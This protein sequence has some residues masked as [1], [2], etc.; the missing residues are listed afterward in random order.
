MS[1]IINS[2]TTSPGGLIS[3]GDSANSLLIQTGDTTAITINSSQQVALT[4]PLGTASGGTGLSTVGTNGQVLSSNG[5]T[6]SWT[7]PSAGFS[8]STINAPSSS[9]LTLTN[10]ST[11]YQVVQITT[12]ANNVV[13]LPNATTLSSEG[14]PV[15]VIQNQSPTGSDLLIKNSA[16]SVIGQVS[17]GAIGLVYLADNSTSA[18]QWE[19]STTTPQ[20]FLQINADTLTTNA[21][22]GTNLNLVGLSTTS[23]VRVSSQNIGSG[24]GSAYVRY[25]LQAGTISGST[26]TFGTVQSFDTP[27][28]TNTQVYVSGQ[29]LQVVRLSN[30]AFAIKYGWYTQIFDGGGTLYGGFNQFRTCTVSGT[31]ISIGSG[32]AG[33]LPF[34]S[35]DASAI[36]RES[37]S[38]NGTLTRLSDTSF[39]VVYNDAVTTSYNNP[40]NF[41]GSL[42]V[43]IVTVS[44][45]TQTVGTKATLGT[46]TYSQVISLAS[47]SSTQLFVCYAQASSAGGSSGRTKLVMVS[48]S[49]TTATWNSPTTVESIDSGLIFNTLNIVNG[50]V[51]PSSTQIVYASGYKT[52]IASLSGTTLTYV[53]SPFNGVLYPLFIASSTLIWTGGR[54]LEYSATGFVT[55]QYGYINSS[56]VSVEANT[57][58]GAQPT[59]LILASNGTGGSVMTGNTL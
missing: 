7:T 34:V 58:L 54:Y 35:D 27:T 42:S 10:T 4:N 43:Q 13:V 36:R 39:A 30:T 25:Y 53:S 8:G 9:V 49:G 26:I 51:S 46:S 20:S 44:G 38:N 14:F 40:Y 59:T 37:F 41:S 29:Q 48:V 47:V 17:I 11:Q 52:N 6:L 45:T 12:S 23:F 18:G 24:S 15:Y 16:G 5:S 21:T 22:T 33:G 57:P 55:T 28:Y 56:G 31:T 2:T 32:T 50:A 19:C 3:T 1:S